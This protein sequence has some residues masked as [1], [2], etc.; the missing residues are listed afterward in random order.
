[1]Q[2]IFWSP[3]GFGLCPYGKIRFFGKKYLKN[4]FY[5]NC[6]QTKVV[7]NQDSQLLYYVT[8]FNIL[9]HFGDIAAYLTH[10]ESIVPSCGTDFYFLFYLFACLFTYLSVYLFT[11]F[12]LFSFIYLCIHLP[13]YY[14]FIFLSLFI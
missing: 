1:M 7:T 2:N 14:F 10:R 11:Y 5:R 9:R 3:R 13:I 8:F 12:R 6:F 4:A